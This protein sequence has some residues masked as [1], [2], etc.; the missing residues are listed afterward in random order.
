MKKELTIV[1]AAV[2]LWCCGFVLAPLLHGG[3]LSDLL[4][5]LYG[6]VCHQ[7]DS[8]SFHLHGEPMAVCIRCSSIYGAFLAAL[9]MIR[10]SQTIREKEITSAPVFIIAVTPMF[11]DGALSTIGLTESTTITRIASGV[12][13]GSGMAMLLHE[14]L[15]ESL[16]QFIYTPK[17]YDTKTG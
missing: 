2:L 4:Y 16:H 11:L 1:I 5:R 13:F 6:T 9:L 7:F 15:C 17:D 14:A 8:R 12:I 10:F 3:W